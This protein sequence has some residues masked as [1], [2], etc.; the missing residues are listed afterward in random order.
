MV[1]PW[2]TPGWC[3]SGGKWFSRPGLAHPSQFGNY[4]PEARITCPENLFLGMS[5]LGLVNEGGIRP[6]AERFYWHASMFVPLGSD[7]TRARETERACEGA[8]G[9]GVVPDCWETVTRATGKPDAGVL[10][11]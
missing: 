9:A 1:G 2:A 7:P 6:N 5:F 3:E 10:C 8:G 4:C 11:G